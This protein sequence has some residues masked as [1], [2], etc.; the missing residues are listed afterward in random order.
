MPVDKRRA[1]I[2]MLC[3]SCHNELEGFIVEYESQYQEYLCQAS[4]TELIEFF[5]AVLYEF[6]S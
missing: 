3:R 6:I 1:E 5:R 2:F 4:H